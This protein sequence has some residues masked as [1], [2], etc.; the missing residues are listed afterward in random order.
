M[1]QDPEHWH[2]IKKHATCIVHL[3]LTIASLGSLVPHSQLRLS[4]ISTPNWQ[5]GRQNLL[6]CVYTKSETF[7]NS[8]PW[9]P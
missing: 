7:I 2:A 9:K 5:Y 8:L 3:F 6:E 4:D 1:R